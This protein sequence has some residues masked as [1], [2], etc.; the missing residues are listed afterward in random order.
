MKQVYIFRCSPASGKS[1]L[2]KEFA[3]LIPGKV[4]FLELDTFRWGFHLVNRDITEVAVTE[5]QLAY[6]NYLSVLE[7]YLADG[8]YT[9]VTEGL[10]SW[11]AESPHGSTKDIIALC[12]KYSRT[13]QS[14]VLSASPETLWHRNSEREYSVPKEEFEELYNHVT[15]EVSDTEFLLDVDSNSVGDSVQILSS[16]LK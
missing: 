8:R 9:I 1:T 13:Y 15:H 16:L 12:E 4:A 2:A 14:I 10:F 5:H 7:N 6:S 3:K 11:N